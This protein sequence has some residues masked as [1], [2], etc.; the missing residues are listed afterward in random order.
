MLIASGI[1]VATEFSK[2]H[3]SLLEENL[4]F[5]T[6][7]VYLISP[8]PLWEEL[9]VLQGARRSPGP[10]LR[11]Q[12]PPQRADPS[13]RHSVQVAGLLCAPLCVSDMVGSVLFYDLSPFQWDHHQGQNI[14]RAIKAWRSVHTAR[15]RVRVDHPASSH[16]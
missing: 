14:D 3:V 10:H 5:F 6:S 12:V 2:A 11:R 4:Y 8:S 15:P 7:S 16:T 13:P 1:S 9:G